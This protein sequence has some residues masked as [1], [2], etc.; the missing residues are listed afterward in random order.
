MEREPGWPV[1]RVGGASRWKVMARFESGGDGVVDGVGDVFGAG[2]NGDVG[3]SA[4]GKGLVGGGIDGGRGGRERARDMDRGEMQ[5]VGAE[6]VGEMDT[7]GHTAHG[8]ADD[9]TEGRVAQIVGGKGILRFWNLLRSRPGADPDLGVRG[10]LC[11]GR[12][13]N[14]GDSEK[15]ADRCEDF[16]WVHW[17]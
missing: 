14:Q 16:C 13:R 5:R 4:E 6:G 12:R 2:G 9:L 10:S 1:S 8:D 15:Q 7:E 3:G 11:G 17:G